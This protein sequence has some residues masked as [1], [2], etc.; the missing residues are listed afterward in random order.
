[1]KKVLLVAAVLGLAMV[2]CKKDYTCECTVT[3]Y[4]N[5]ASASQTTSGATGKMKKADATSKC[6]K[7][8]SM[9]GDTQNGIKSECSI[10]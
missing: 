4:S 2:S 8:D 1:M 5:G 6:D 10:K 9:V 7:G 3:T